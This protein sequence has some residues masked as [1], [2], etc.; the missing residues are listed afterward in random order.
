MNLPRPVGHQKKALYLP[1][2]GHQVVLGSAGTG[3]TVMAALRAQYLS[4]PGIEGHG[5]TLLVTST[6]ALS[7]YL[8]HMSRG[9]PEGLDVRTYG[10]FARGYLNSRGLMRGRNIVDSRARRELVGQA[11]RAV[12]DHYP[13]HSLFGRKVEWFEDELSWITGMGFQGE[14]AYLETERRRRSRI[15]ENSRSIVWE[16]LEHYHDLRDEKGYDFDWDDIAITV[17][18]ELAGDD[19]PRFYRHVVIDEG[20]DLSPE[21]IRSLADAV[22]PDGSVSFF[23]DYA[24]QIYGQAMSW[25]SCGLAVRKVER[26][27]DNF[28]NTKAIA[29]VA[30]E[31]SSQPFFGDSEDLVEPIA[32]KVDGAKPTLVECQDEQEEME[33]VRQTARRLS[34]EGTVAVVGRTWEEAERLCRGLESLHV[35]KNPY[36]WDAPP[37]VYRSTYYSV[38]GLEF[39]SVIVP[40]CGAAHMPSEEAL[41]AFGEEDAMA[42]EAKLL[43]VAITRA[44][45]D[46]V[47]TYS[48]KYPPLLSSSPG[49]FTEVRP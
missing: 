47:L 45:S 25:K 8:Q 7:G 16:I 28:R 49:L 3:K 31:L 6:K 24:Q 44:K 26:F 41:D 34:A 43:Y 40:F 30:I 14:D 21:E 1:S 5:R 19:Q 27:Q 11:I 37:G 12:A 33:I 36:S 35:K 15:P 48:G 2:S 42:R 29:K 17:R 46:L 10:H 23:G 20:Q 38:K 39:D 13:G 9:A 18:K 4:T 32:P 22:P